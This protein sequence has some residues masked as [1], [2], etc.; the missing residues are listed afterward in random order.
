MGF[1]HQLFHARRK[2]SSSLLSRSAHRP[3]RWLKI[4]R[5]LGLLFFVGSVVGVI[6][7]TGLFL[8]IA[9]DLPNPAGVT[10]QQGLSTKINDR[11]GN[12]LYSVYHDVQSVPVTIDQVPTYLKEATVSTEDKE[13]YKEG[14]FDPLGPLRILYNVLR[15]HHLTGASTLTQQLVRNTIISNERTL[16]R[17]FKEFLLAIQIDNIYSKDEI[18]QMYLNNA[19]YGGTALGVGAAAQ[20]Y[21]HKDVKDLTLVE[22][23]ILAGLPQSPSNYSPISGKKDSNGVPLWLPRAQG[24]LRRMREDGDITADQE[25]TADDQLSAMKF[26]KNAISINAPHFVFYVRDQLEQMFGTTMVEQGG[27]KVTTTLDLNLQQQAQQ[28]VQDE[29]A[30]VNNVHIT[31]GAAMVLDPKDGEILAMVGSK[32]YFAT[33][34][35]GQFNVAVDGSRQ[36]GS[37][38]KP[39][40]YVLAFRKGFTPASMI[41][42]APTSFPG[43]TGQPDYA[44]QNYDGKFHG[45]V[46]LRFALANSMNI[47]AVKLLAQVGVKDMLGLAYQMGFKTLE[48]SVVNQRRFGLSVT[49]GGGEVHLIDE[50]GAYSAFAN[51]GLKVDPV[52]I[53]KVEDKDGHVLYQANPQAGDRVLSPQETFLIDSVLSDNDARSMEFGS[54]SQLNFGGRAVAVK[55]GTTN[56][57]VDNWTVGWTQN[58]IVGVWVGNNDNSPMKQVASGITGAAPIWHRIMDTAIKDGYKDVPW[59]IPSGV[60]QQTVDSISG[61]PAHDNFPSRQEYIIDGTLP[62]LPDPIHTNLKVCAGQNA[63]ASEADIARGQYDQKE[64]IVLK[65]NDPVSQDGQN[66]WQTGIDTWV[67]QQADP[68]YHVPTGTCSSGSVVYANI[69]SPSDQSNFSDG[70]SNVPISVDATTD[71]DIDRVEIYVDDVLTTTLRSR[72]YNTTLSLSHGTHKLNARAFRSSDQSEGI[73]GDVHIGVGVPWN[74]T[75]PTPTPTSTPTA[76]P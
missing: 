32:N 70:N 48:P 69:T 37:S 27:L 54:N 6:V 67:S 65:E 71:G 46:E 42:D 50:V 43:G 41:V 14:G 28:I 45:P 61:Y 49:L 72:P 7:F 21:F 2:R 34:I 18:L 23:A 58:A 31:N 8:W 25:K 39:V 38:I 3:F 53:L 60:T 52:A 15:F 56:N 5:F 59:T 63:L 22:C 62:S 57:K 68:R 47:P 4:L 76:S 10:V 24:V 73:S 75:A 44:P 36:P 29:V 11:N 26:D 17:K 16:T 12:L 40:T 35:D 20:L 66:R 19:P 74:Y 55:T 30:K 9:R 64:F 33:D 13:F 1:V 51:G